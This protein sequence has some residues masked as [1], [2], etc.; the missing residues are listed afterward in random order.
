MLQ[1]TDATDDSLKYLREGIS[2]IPLPIQKQIREAHIHVLLAPRYVD[3]E[4]EES[5][6]QVFRGGGDTEN[7]GGCFE[8][9]RNRVLI[10]ERA[11]W[12]HGPPKPQGRYLI[13]VARHEL[14]HA[15]DSSLHHISSS[16]EFIKEYDEDF[17]HLSNSQC[18]KFAY[19][20]T[21]VSKSDA[22]VPTASGRGECWASMMGKLCSPEEKRTDGF[23]EAFPHVR[24][25]MERLEPKLLVAPQPVADERKSR[26]VSSKV[27]PATGQFI[28]N[29]I[30]SDPAIAVACTRAQALIQSA[31][32]EE[33]LYCLNKAINDF[34]GRSRLYFIRG[35]CYMWLHQ[36]KDAIKN[37]NAYIDAFPS[38]VEAHRQRANA[39]GWLGQAGRQ[40]WDNRRADQLARH[41]AE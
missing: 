27:E 33:A 4:P 23:L 6:K 28:K 11:S 8:P 40:D 39:Y 30:N 10:P 41:P 15:W 13:G 26:T 17:S 32:Y 37:Y 25:F 18:Q 22:N 5:G 35:N 24:K 12:R 7:I 2:T 3:A 20:I 21:G 19:F 38:V 34:P 29:N 1:H 14:G 16:P 36:Y 31:K 9:H